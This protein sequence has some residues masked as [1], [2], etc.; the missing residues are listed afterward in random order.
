MSPLS[1]P[2]GLIFN[3]NLPSGFIP[4]RDVPS[5]HRGGEKGGGGVVLRA[6][7]AQ[8]ETRGRGGF[9]WVSLRWCVQCNIVARYLLCQAQSGA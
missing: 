5:D 3:L 1:P 2:N 7:S 8:R 4:V 9:E 6:R